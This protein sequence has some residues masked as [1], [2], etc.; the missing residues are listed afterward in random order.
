MKLSIII[1]PFTVTSMISP[2]FAPAQSIYRSWSDWESLTVSPRVC[3]CLLDSR[4]TGPAGCAGAGSKH[5]IIRA[6][7]ADRKI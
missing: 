2:R 4:N 7:L 5:G 1:N 6:E 3:R